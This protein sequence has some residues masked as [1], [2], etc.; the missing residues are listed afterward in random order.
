M[1]RTPRRVAL[2]G[3][4]T[5]ALGLGALAAPAA[6]G[7]PGPPQGRIVHAGAPDAVAGSYLVR[8]RESAAAPRAGSAGAERVAERHGAEVTDAFPLTLNGLA[9]RA[10]EAEARELAADPAVLS[11]TQDRLVRGAATQPSPPSWG[12]DRVDQPNLPLDRSYT[13]PDGGGEGVTIYVLDTGIR[14]GHVDFG[15]RAAFGYDRWSSG[16]NDGYGHG[17]HVAA[18]A[19]GTSYGVAKAADLVSVRVLDDNNTGT[20]TSIVAGVEWVTAN[21][22]GPAVA[23]MSLIGG[24]NGLID[25]AV[26]ASIASGVTYVV[27]AGNNTGANAGSYSPARVAEAVTVASST[28][29]DARSGFSNIGPVVDI[30]AP[31]TDIVSAWYSSDTASRSWSGTS[32]AAPHVAGAAALYLADHPGA[33]PAEVRD[34]LVAAAKPGGIAQPGANTTGALLQVD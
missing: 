6:A 17:T 29:T 23:N 26:R 30:Y 16:G 14:Y 8:L 21:A 19:G 25:D 7:A 20:T 34:A 10:T 27:A 11:V 32:M 28:N 33:T 3:A 5:F 15:G 2:A 12:L 24:A 13:Y 18:T 4:L 9:V 31:G 22:E 1:K